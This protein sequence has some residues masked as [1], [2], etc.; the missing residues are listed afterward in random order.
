MTPE[1]MLASLQEEAKGLV[2]TVQRFSSEKRISQQSVELG[3]R[4]DSNDG[5]RS[6]ATETN[7]L[8][9]S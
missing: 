8:Q 9:W 4:Q 1:Q 5:K 7:S 6:C 2:E 3:S